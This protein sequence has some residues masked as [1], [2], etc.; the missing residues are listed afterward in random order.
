MIAGLADDP[1]QL[2]ED[3]EHRHQFAA[4]E[5]ERLARHGLRR[6]HGRVHAIGD[7]GVAANLQAVA[8]ELDRLALQ[9]RVDEQVVAHLGALPRAVDAEEPQHDRRDAELVA[10]DAA[11]VARPRVS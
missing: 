1:L 5:V 10:V 9:D 7:V 4:A 6:P 11:E 2:A 8:G 3:L